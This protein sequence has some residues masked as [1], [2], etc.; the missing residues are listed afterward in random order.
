[1]GFSYKK[2][3]DAAAYWHNR[4]ETEL[5]KCVKEEKANL[6]QI[7]QRVLAGYTVSRQTNLL[8]DKSYDTI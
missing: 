5:Q 8:G 7:Y 1:M 3:Y 6:N 2:E 4:A